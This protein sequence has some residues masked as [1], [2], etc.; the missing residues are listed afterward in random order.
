MHIVSHRSSLAQVWRYLVYLRSFWFG[1]GWLPTGFKHGQ[2]PSC[3]TVSELEMQC[4][5]S[6]FQKKEMDGVTVKNEVCLTSRPFKQENTQEMLFGWWTPH[7]IGILK[8]E[9]L[10]EDIFLRRKTQNFQLFFQIW[11]WD[12]RHK[13][14]HNYTLK[15][16][17]LMS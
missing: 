11:V 2:L 3:S 17:L 9:K 10:Y 15:V 6:F 8:E 1:R 12:D 5:R 7:M 13:K 14:T 16:F 4:R